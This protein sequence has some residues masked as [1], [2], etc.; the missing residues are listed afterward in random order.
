MGWMFEEKTHDERAPTMSN[1]S[2]LL[3]QPF[4]THMKKFYFAHIMLKVCTP[5]ITASV[6]TYI[7]CVICA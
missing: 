4:Y 1:A 3:K 7:I 2:D 5:A 6:Y